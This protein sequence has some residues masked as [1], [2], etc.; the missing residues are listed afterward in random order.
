[1]LKMINRT[2]YL[3]GPKTLIGTAIFALLVW[4]LWNP[5]SYIL[6]NIIAYPGELIWK[7][8]SAFSEGNNID[9][10]SNL[11]VLISRM[12][13]AERELRSLREN[14]GYKAN[15]S[16]HL[17]YVL[18]SLSSSPYDTFMIDQGKDAGVLFG[19]K[20]VTSEGVLL[21]EVKEVYQHIAKVQMY[22][23]S[24]NEFEVQVDGIGRAMTRGRGSQN[25]YLE[26]PK[27]FPVSASSTLFAPGQEGLVVAIVE[28]IEGNSGTAF[29]KIYA[30]QPANIHSLD[31]V[32][33]TQ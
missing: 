6:V 23:A 9:L 31:R 3:L 11:V 19:Q 20:V 18:S 4:R 29:Q 7:A 5:I 2:G 10:A 33:V 30:R 12:N 27:G 24:G 28:R 14:L 1:M 25:Y 32:Y 22:S 8:A 15:E 16:R 17:A 21:G 13:L 26:L